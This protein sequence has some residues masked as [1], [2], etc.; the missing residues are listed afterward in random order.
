M[1]EMSITAPFRTLRLLGLIAAL[2]LLLAGCGASDGPADAS[3][4]LNYKQALAGAPAPLAALYKQPN[5]LLD[6]GVDAYNKRL[7]TLHGH[8]VVVNK[9][10]SWCGPCR[11]EF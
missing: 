9:W 2:A 10:A 6:G 3:K 1:T 7:D 4:D 11:F 8:P 5:A